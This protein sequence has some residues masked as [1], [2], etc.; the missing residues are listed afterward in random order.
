VPPDQKAARE[1]DLR[2]RCVARLRA[3]GLLHAG[4]ALQDGGGRTGWTN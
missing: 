1:A 3:D 4:G 2:R